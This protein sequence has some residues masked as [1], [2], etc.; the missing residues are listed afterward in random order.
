M[1]T[2]T[3]DFAVVFASVRRECPDCPDLVLNAKEPNGT[4]I[5]LEVEPEPE[6]GR[7]QYSLSVKDGELIATF[8]D[9]F[10]LSLRKD[11]GLPPGHLKHRHWRPE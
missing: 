10:E 5:V 11:R 2:A 9:R 7:K 1:T 3:D 8:I 6:L 4:P